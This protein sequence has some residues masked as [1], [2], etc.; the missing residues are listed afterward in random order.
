MG[1]PDV[2]LNVGSGSAA[3]VKTDVDDG[4]IPRSGAVFL[5]FCWLWSLLLYFIMIRRTPI[6]WRWISLA[7]KVLTASM[8]TSVIRPFG[9]LEDLS[10]ILLGAKLARSKAGFGGVAMIRMG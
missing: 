4:A 1:R 10:L 9:L 8:S 3:K 5:D 2:A 7:L 6:G